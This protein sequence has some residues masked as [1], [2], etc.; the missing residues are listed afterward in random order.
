MELKQSEQLDE[1]KQMILTEKATELLEILTRDVR[2][3]TREQV[4]RTVY[5]HVKKPLESA[6]RFTKN[7][8]GQ[9]LVTAWPAMVAPVTAGNPLL[10][11]R[12][13]DD[14]PNFHRVAWQNQKRWSVPLQRTTCI[15]PTKK[16]HGLFG[17]SPRRIRSRE[18]EHDL[19]LTDVF[20]SLRE[21]SPELATHWRHEDEMKSL[22]LHAKRPDAI[23]DAGEHIIIIDVLGRGYDASKIEQIWRCHQASRLL[24]H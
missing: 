19:L 2:G 4:A 12:P 24:L 22:G 15:A 9:D 7:L 16:A 17:G 11:W 14:E 18:L 13:G 10:D 23:I 6:T 20:L 21:T 3:M 8:Q 1:Q 5:A